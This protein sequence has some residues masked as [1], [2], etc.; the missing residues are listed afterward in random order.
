MKRKWGVCSYYM[1]RW[2]RLIVAQLFMSS[3]PQPIS[4]LYSEGIDHNKNLTIGK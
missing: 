4:S 3:Y 1:K 2:L